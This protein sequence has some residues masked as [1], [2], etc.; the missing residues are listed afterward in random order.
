[1]RNKVAKRLRKIAHRETA[2]AFSD[3]KMNIKKRRVIED[4]MIKRRKIY[5][6]MKRMYSRGLLT[7]IKGKQ[8]DA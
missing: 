5:R 4:F 8:A 7:I 1:L 6:R 2:L 3:G